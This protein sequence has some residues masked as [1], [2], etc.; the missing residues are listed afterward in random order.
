M[1]RSPRRIVEHPLQWERK[2]AACRWQKGETPQAQWAADGHAI[3]YL[4]RPADAHKL[5]A[6]RD[7]DAGD[8]RRAGRGL[9]NRRHQP[10]RAVP[11]QRGR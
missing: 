9:Q 5:T 1:Y 7:M 6:L 11:G 4:N 8:R 10:V 3:E 2:I